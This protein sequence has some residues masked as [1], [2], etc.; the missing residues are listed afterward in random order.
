MTDSSLIMGILEF[1]SY[2]RRY[3][4]LIQKM[5]APE[6]DGERFKVRAFSTK[7]TK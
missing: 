4:N 2:S 3:Q 1:I 7:L 5:E 6:I